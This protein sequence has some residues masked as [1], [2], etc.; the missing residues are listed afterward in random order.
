MTNL[1]AASYILYTLL[2]KLVPTINFLLNWF[3]MHQLHEHQERKAINKNKIMKKLKI[4]H[5]LN[6]SLSK[7]NQQYSEMLFPLKQEWNFTWLMFVW[8]KQVWPSL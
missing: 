5:L 6:L 8:V 7:K 2:A 1:V 3:L 4:G